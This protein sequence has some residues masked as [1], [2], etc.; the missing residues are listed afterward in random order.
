[1]ND[2]CGEL[3]ALLRARPRHAF[4]YRDAALCSNGLYV[5]FEK[6]EAGHGGDRIVRV[7]THRGDNNLCGRLKE[8]F[9]TPNKDRSIFRKHVGRALLHRDGDPFLH[10]WDTD[11]TTAA[12]RRAP[13]AT[14]GVRQSDV[15]QCVTD[16]I[17]SNLS[18]CVIEV[19]TKFDRRRWEDLLIATA[20]QCPSCAPS[21]GWLGRH[22]PVTKIRAGKLW[23]V[24]GVNG[25]P[26]S[27]ETLDEFARLL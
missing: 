4:P 1:M 8:H 26:L 13:S 18:F 19:A 9:L 7:G 14:D 27:R 2:L 3:H 22:S 11:R 25:T 23:Q 15:E 5:L 20:A 10:A 16:F 17:R 21:P 24:Q 12:S 6:G